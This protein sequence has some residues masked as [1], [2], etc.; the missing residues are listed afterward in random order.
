MVVNNQSVKSGGFSCKP[1][2]SPE[3]QPGLNIVQTPRETDHRVGEH[4]VVVNSVG[5]RT[6]AVVRR[7]G[8]PQGWGP[9]HKEGR[10]Q[11]VSFGS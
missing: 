3:R 1:S 10:I 7:N 6:V 5:N 4:S 8:G 9:P 11:E 2:R